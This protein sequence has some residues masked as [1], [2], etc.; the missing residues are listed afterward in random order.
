MPRD[1]WAQWRAE[2]R[3]VSEPLPNTRLELTR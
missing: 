3:L 2:A 1:S